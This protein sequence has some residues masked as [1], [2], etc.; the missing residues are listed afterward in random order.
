[1]L[2]CFLGWTEEWEAE[3][4]SIDFLTE[5]LAVGYE[6]ESDRGTYTESGA[7]IEV[8]YWSI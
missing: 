6:S 1:M 3:D 8:R 7:I 4:R 2:A 5:A